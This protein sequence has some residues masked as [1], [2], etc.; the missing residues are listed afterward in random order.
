MPST[1]TRF[2]SPEDI[3]EKFRAYAASHGW[4]FSEDR[5]K[6]L[7]RETPASHV[8][9]HDSVLTLDVWLGSLYATFEHLKAWIDYESQGC[10]RA[11]WRHP[12]LAADPAHLR[13]FDS[14]RYGD[15]LTVRWVELNMFANRSSPGTAVPREIRAPETSAG[16]QVL[17]ALALHS[18]VYMQETPGENYPEEVVLAGLEYGT[19]MN[20]WVFAPMLQWMANGD[21]VLNGEILDSACHRDWALP[22]VRDLP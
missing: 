9:R 6:Q 22:E 2:S 17:T 3:V 7:E 16:L 13:L 12:T 15:E 5:L 20:G 19:D 14:T 10:Y 1:G 18:E 4:P 21:V 8:S 11:I